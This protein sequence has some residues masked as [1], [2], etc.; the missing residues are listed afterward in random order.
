[1]AALKPGDT[2]VVASHNAGKVRE[3]DE[4]FAPFGLKVVS[5]GRARAS[6]S[7]TRPATTFE[8]N[9]EIK[10]VAAATASGLPALADNSGLVVDALGGDP[11]V[12]S[13]RWAGPDKDFAAPC[14]RR[15]EAGRRGA[16]TP[17]S[18]PRASSPS[19]ASPAPSGAAEFWRGEVEG[20]LVWPPRGTQGFGYDPIFLP[21]GHSRTFG[22][23]SADEKHGWKIGEG[24]PLSHRARAFARFAGAKLGAR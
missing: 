5:A 8:E 15:G 10:A 7:R 3:I 18:A 22:E 16:T 13:A 19:S 24:E 11:G 21:H 6:P 9:A 14:A 23:M 17:R 20:T 12:Y 2:L 1:M 4:L